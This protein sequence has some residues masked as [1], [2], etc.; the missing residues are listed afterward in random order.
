M[1]VEEFKSIFFW[2]WGHRVLGR[3]AG[4]AFVVPL[5]YFAVRRRLTA[6]LPKQLAAMALL[7]AGQGFMG[8]YMVK[9][10]LDH[11]LMETPGAVPRVSHYRLASH[12]CL[13]FLLYAGMFVGG[14]STLMDW[15]YAHTGIWSGVSGGDVAWKNVLTKP[16]VRR[17]LSRSKWLCGLVFVT[18]MSGQPKTPGVRNMSL[19][20]YCRCSGRRSRCRSAL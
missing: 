6:T 7:F 9:S 3:L 16:A 19:I 5:A 20:E 17:F 10:G 18:A 12:L 13:A 8:W 1:N 4:V 11:S 2:E 14:I 15:R